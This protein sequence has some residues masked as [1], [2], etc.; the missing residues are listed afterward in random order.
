[1]TQDFNPLMD[2]ARKVECSVRVPSNGSW[3]DDDVITFNSLNEV[4]IKPMLPIDELNI[5]NPELLISGKAIID[6]IKSC[7]PGVHKPEELYYPDLNT[8]MLGVR[9]AT[10][11]N[12][13]TQE[14]ICPKC[15]EK[16]AEIEKE[17]VLEIIDKEY[18]GDESKLSTTEITALI[19]RVRK[20]CAEQITQMEKNNEIRITPQSYVLDIDDILNRTKMLPKEVV[21]ETS[22]GLKMFLTPYKCIDKIKFSNRNLKQKKILLKH[23][24]NMDNNNKELETMEDLQRKASNAEDIMSLYA[25][26]TTS[27]LELLSLSIH[28]IELPNG[29]IVENKDFI[30]EF[31]K[32]CPAELVSQLNDKITDINGYGIPQ[33]IELSCQCCGHTWDENFY[34][35][36]QMDFFGISS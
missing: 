32:N 22:S 11:G 5:V 15:N 33:T 30:T 27:N 29:D 31:I 26:L 1:M 13:L 18:G 16:R 2:F 12:E 24:E 3:Y 10:Y 9:K 14:S 35:F 7:C 8:I 25:D 36:N 17:R 34:G 20:D 21:I 23:K 19:E 4:D 28:H 6:I